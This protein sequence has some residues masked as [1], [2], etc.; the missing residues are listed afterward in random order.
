MALRAWEGR[1]G[2]GA[3]LAVLLAAPALGQHLPP[4]P[5]LIERLSPAEPPALSPRALPPEPERISG[6]GE[7]RRVALGAVRVEGAT[8]LRP[9]PD[10]PPGATVTLAEI[11]TARLGVLRAY[12]EA[13]FPYVAVAAVLAPR[14]G[15]AP[16]LV[17]RVTEGVISAV[18]LEGEGIGPVA[19]RLRGM[20]E[21]LIGQRPLSNAAL[22]RALLLAGDLPGVDA[23]GVLRPEGGPGELRLIVQVARRP[24]TGLFNLDNRGFARTGAWQGLLNLGVNSLT[25]FGERTELALVGT[26]GAGQGFAQVTHEV[27]ISGAGTRLRA[28]LGAGRAT[29]GS[30]LAAIGYVGETRVAG[31]ALTHPL[32]RSRP[33]NLTLL[34]ALDAFESTVE[35]RDA[36]G[37]ARTRQSHDAV[38]ALR[39][40]FE[41]SALDGA[42][43][44]AP[45]AGITTGTL[46]LHRGLEAFGA[47]DGDSGRTSRRGSD[48]GFTKVTAEVTRLQPLLVPAEGWLLATQGVLAGQWSD[49]VLPP[50]ERFFLGGNRLGRGFYTGQ[51]T[52]D[53]ALAASGELQLGRQ[54]DLALG[55]DALRLGT[56]F[57]LFRDEGRGADNGPGGVMRRL[58]SYGGG[59]RVQ[60]DERVQLDLELARRMTR[61]PEGVGVTRL[62][63]DAVFARVLLRF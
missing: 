13:G 47:S 22:E 51:V 5:G 35:A 34:A 32:I 30:P 7:S 27:V 12:R 62:D 60:F 42:L 40:G 18:T 9:V 38:R 31:M 63:A 10:V 26:D 36:P 28:Y 16:D 29:P 17:F 24:V 53:R 45:A 4:L 49:D 8:A 20:L 25:R 56:Q 55:A 57:Y 43:G 59:V 44:F 46:R 33:L 2:R 14:A 15:A 48:F 50:A 39:F 58:A 37:L 19:A 11:E 23:R 54:F 52:G 6:A 3:C 61:N 1:A 21:P 41:A